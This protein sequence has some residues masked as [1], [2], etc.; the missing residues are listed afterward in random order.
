MSLQHLRRALFRREGNA[1]SLPLETRRVR[2]RNL[3][4]PNVLECLLISVH[5]LQRKCNEKTILERARKNLLASKLRFKKRRFT[6]HVSIGREDRDVFKR[7]R[8]EV[9]EHQR[10]PLTRTDTRAHDATGAKR[11]W[12]CSAVRCSATSVASPSRARTRDALLTRFILLS[13]SSRLVG[14][15]SVHILDKSH[16]RYFGSSS[17]ISSIVRQTFIA[18]QPP[19]T[20]DV[21]VQHRVHESRPFGSR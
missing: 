9:R 18:P 10:R 19:K 11:V 13:L 1:S 21:V 7:V 3:Y 2:N 8:R 16:A 4:S 12:Y 5:I 6:R 20:K 15:F 17:F 14:R